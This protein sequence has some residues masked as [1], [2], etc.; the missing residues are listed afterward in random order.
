MTTREDFEEMLSHHARWQDNGA[1]IMAAWDAL[2]AEMDALRTGVPLTAE[3]APRARVVE[4]KD[5]VWVWSH[6]I[7]WR[8]PGS[9]HEYALTGFL[10]AFGATVLAWRKP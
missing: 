1:S 8:L 5:A 10:V 4:C 6:G 9:D 2:A 3:N 7:V